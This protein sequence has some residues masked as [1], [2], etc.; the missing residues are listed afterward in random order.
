[1]R[2]VEFKE[3]LRKAAEVTPSQSASLLTLWK[4]SSQIARLGEQD[5]RE[6]NLERAYMYYMR[7]VNILV[8]IAPKNPEY[9]RQLKIERQRYRDM[10]EGLIANLEKI[11]VIL[12]ERYDAP[13]PLPSPPSDPA[14]PPPS[15]LPEPVHEEKQ[16]DAQ[17]PGVEFNNHLPEDDASR[18]VEVL[19]PSAPPPVEDG[20]TDS[21][22]DDT[23]ANLRLSYTTTIPKG[24]NSNVAHSPPTPS[25]AQILKSLSEPCR[26]HI[27]SDAPWEFLRIAEPNTK[28]DV[29]TLGILM[30]PRIKNEFFVTHIFLPKQVGT[31]NTVEQNDEME[32]LD[33]SLSNDMFTLGWIHTHPS[34]SC[35]LSSVDLHTQFSYQRQLDEA[36][37]I[38]MAPSYKENIGFFSI[39]RKGM[40]VIKDCGKRGFHEHGQNE[41]LYGKS[42]HVVVRNDLQPVKIVDARSRNYSKASK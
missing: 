8:T 5:E 17:Q 3:Q 34:Q 11:T 37:G 1:M 6:G 40:D 10:A 12:Q 33:F 9:G 38:V 18:P 35:F 4:M 25:Q 23:F 14:L 32:L 2:W 41:G 7:A 15:S 20:N 19:A 42:A 21:D 27:P 24:P 22:V 16:L 36:I 26:M 28:R 30:G 29:E 31:S 39:T 13:T